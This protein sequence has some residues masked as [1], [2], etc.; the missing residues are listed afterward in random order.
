MRKTE[1]KKTSISKKKWVK[2]KF[3]KIF[4]N[5]NPGP[6]ADDAMTAS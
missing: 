3:E 6:G 5:F 4:L 1:R 2:P